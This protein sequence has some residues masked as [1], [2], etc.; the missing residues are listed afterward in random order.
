MTK[1]FFFLA[2]AGVL[3]TE[4][5]IPVAWAD[6]IAEL[7]EKIETTQ[8]SYD[9][10]LSEYNNALQ[11]MS[12]S[13][14]ELEAAEAAVDRRKEEMEAAL[15]KLR[16]VQEFALER[17]DVSD[18]KEKAA[19]AVAKA[20][21]GEARRLLGEKT[22]QLHKMKTDA[23]SILTA[24]KGYR[25]EL[26]NLNRQ[27]ATNRFRKLQESLSHESTV[28]ARG[29]FGCED[30][31]VRQCRDGAL[32][33]ARRSAVEQASAVILDSATVMEDLRV[34]VG[35]DAVAE[36]RQMMKDR[37]ESHVTGILVSYEVL[38]K[39]WVGEAGYFYE[40]EAVVKGQVSEEFF[41]IA[42][43][44]DLPVLPEPDEVVT[45]ARSDAASEQAH[46]APLVDDPDH[47]VLRLVERIGTERDR[48]ESQRTK[49]LEQAEEAYQAG[50]A[51][52][53]PKDM[54]ES[55]AEY[56]ARDAREKSEI[57]LERARTTT[58]VHRKYDSLLEK[59]V[60]P[61]VKR[62]QAQLGRDDVVPEAAIE[63][64]LQTYDAENGVFVGG[65]Q[66][67]SLLMKKTG[68]L[69]LP[70][71]K[72]AARA[73]WKN[74][75]S[76]EGKVR[77]FLEARSLDIGIS[78]FWLEDS[79]SGQKARVTVIEL[80]TSP[81]TGSPSS[82]KVS[83]AQLEL[84]KA[85]RL[86]ASDL[87][88]RAGKG[89]IFESTAKGWV[90]EYNRLIGEASSV[91]AKDPLL[92]ALRPLSYSG[93]TGQTA[94]AVATAASGVAAYL[95]SFAPDKAF[96]KVA[97][98]LAQRAGKGVIFEPTAKGWVAEYN[99]LIGEAS[100]VLAKDP[101][102]RALRPLSYSG[103]TGQ[104]A[105]AVA[106]AASGVAAYLGSFAPD[107]AFGKVASGLA[108][109]AGKGVIFE[110]TAKGWVAEYNRLIG[111]ASSVLAKDPLLRALRPLSYSG[112]TG[113]T[114]AAVATAASGVAAYLGSFAP[115]KAFGKVASGLAQRAGKGV[116]F[117]PTA[118]GWVAEYNRLI[119]EASSVLA[120]DP[121]VRAL[122]PL[123]YS[124]DEDQMA[125]AVATA[126]GKLVRIFAAVEA[127]A[128]GEAPSITGITN[129][130][131]VEYTPLDY[132]AYSGRFSNTALQLE[133]ALRRKFSP[134]VVDENG[135]TD[136]HYAAALNLPGLAS[137]LL[138]AGAEPDA[139]LKSDLERPS[140]SLNSML[141]AFGRSL[142]SWWKRGGESPLHIAAKNEAELAASHLVESGSNVDM[143]SVSGSAPL[144]YAAY[145]NSQAIAELLIGQGVDVGA[146][147]ASG[148]RTPLDV[149]VRSEAAGT[150]ALLRRHGGSCKS[151]RCP[152]R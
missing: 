83:K 49:E 41:R 96:G 140:D 48:I 35:S 28:V 52:I 47:E 109:R 80:S 75:E 67:D 116:I 90:A 97:S 124:G 66:I 117:E 142:P 150:I 131:T 77:L 56:H 125:A 82:T 58:A 23:T 5:L 43:I 1:F 151:E 36:E 122:K 127:P 87:A 71:K 149:A 69:Y 65:L 45:R 15:E 11:A 136:L 107:K 121:L 135:W 79:K 3:L 81:T 51:T 114:A 14:G 78:G 54:F 18:E 115:D 103:D 33:L 60:E 68:R 57:T 101:L 129:P 55:E 4:G 143:E 40:I 110:P 86:S 27:V 145:S 31:T 8:D 26:Q 111:E 76:L 16:K 152:A 17:S 6:T 32:E 50:W 30:V 134:D 119:G 93:D 126:A 63:F 89:V 100:S 102:L 106:T 74:R 133:K 123:S 44:E 95:G 13:R 61:L 113:Q 120:K 112:D 132:L 137:A 25:G 29:E 21:H 85:T 98:G 20:A 12:A 130:N 46:A 7:G 146:R 24:L 59:N 39:G 99:R 42:G 105:A 94:A 22:E 108:Q 128:R 139:R 38:D 138:D 70:M 62:A 144:C 73:F 141:S 88:Q 148:K 84:A 37:I 53:E 104:T 92:R 72:K 147:C 64:E 2:F 91:L 118:K 10:A 34:F 9:A 19:Y